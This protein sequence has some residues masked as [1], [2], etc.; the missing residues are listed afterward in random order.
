MN[1]KGFTFIELLIVVAIIG[2]LAIIAIPRFN[3]YRE[4]AQRASNRMDTRNVE[5]KAQL[6]A[7][8]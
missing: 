3:S 6:D 2:T 7:A 5:I 1:K 8:E 4:G